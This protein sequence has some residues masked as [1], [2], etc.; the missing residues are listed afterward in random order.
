MPR[1]HLLSIGVTVFLVVCFIVW[2]VFS[3]I[4]FIALWKLF[5]KAG[6]VPWRLLIPIG[7]YCD[8]LELSGFHGLFCLLVM[9]PFFYIGLI[10]GWL[11]P[12]L[13]YRRFVGA[14]QARA[15]KTLIPFYGAFLSM[16]I[17]ND[18]ACQYDGQ[19]FVYKDQGIQMSSFT[20]QGQNFQQDWNNMQSQWQKGNAGAQ[21]SP[22]NYDRVLSMHKVMDRVLVIRQ[23]RIMAMLKVVSSRAVTDKRYSIKVL[24]RES[25]GLTSKFISSLLRVVLKEVQALIRIFSLMT[26]HGQ[27]MIFVLTSK[28]NM[29]VASLPPLAS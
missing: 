13:L 20:N 10:I 6:Y 23:Y 18:P 8:I 28:N 1:F 21:P 15:W 26:K 29:A 11:M 4:R 9:I 24:Y 7:A 27:R 17:A 19:R 16:K 22:M 2:A 3:V 5:K 14:D 25:R 12:V